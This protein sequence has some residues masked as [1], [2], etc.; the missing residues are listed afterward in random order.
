[1]RTNTTAKPELRTEVAHLRDLAAL[2]GT[3]VTFY[4]AGHKGGSG[5]RPMRVRLRAMLTEAERL[6]EKRGVMPTDRESLLEPLRTRAN[7][8]ELGSG[9]GASLAVFRSSRRFEQVSLPWDVE[10]TVAVEGRPL[11]TPLMQGRNAHPEFL[12]LAVSKQNTRLFE[13]GPASQRLLDWPAGTPRGLAEFEGFDHAD[14]TQGRTGGGVKFGL[15]TFAEK[16]PNYLH[17][18]CRALDRAL[19]P[20]LENRGLPLVLAG[21]TAELVAY[22]SANRY[23]LLVP[24]AVEGSPDGGLSDAELAEKGRRAM[25]GWRPGEARHALDLYLRAGPGKKSAEI[26]EILRAAAAGRVLHLFLAGKAGQT[27]DVEKILGRVQPSGATSG[28]HDHLDNAAAVETLRH[29][30][31]VWMVDDPLDG[32][33]AAAVF[34]W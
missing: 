3:C 4:L 12:L 23:P 6:L 21:A 17:D 26:E 32:S 1:M 27:G 5:S 15:D 16:E 31:H 22:R 29:N 34:R 10:D 18:F 9:H 30:G 25:Q 19:Q 14:H 7:D 24:T 20:V 2:E 33:A 28:E 13:C 8:P 11:L